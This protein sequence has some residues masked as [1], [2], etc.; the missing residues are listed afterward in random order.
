MSWEKILKFRVG[1]TRIESRLITSVMSDGI[2]RTYD[3]IM[4]EIYSKKKGG[5]GKYRWLASK[6]TT[7]AYLGKYYDKTLIGKDE[8][9][10]PIYEYS[11]KG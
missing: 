4:D 8:F 9:R 2:S 6:A 3:R 10:R 11:R 1:L 5:G 7:I